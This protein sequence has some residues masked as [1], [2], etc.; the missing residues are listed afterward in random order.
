VP[1]LIFSRVGPGK[2]QVQL[3]KFSIDICGSSWNGITA[4]PYRKK[5]VGMWE[6]ALGGMLAIWR[7]RF[8]VIADGNTAMQG[9]HGSYGLMGNQNKH[10]ATPVDSGLNIPL[11]LA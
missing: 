3:P 5:R 6:S 7:E 9:F 8:N 10:I 2:V 11:L 4:K 1:P